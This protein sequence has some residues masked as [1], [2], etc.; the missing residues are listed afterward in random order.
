MFINVLDELTQGGTGQSWVD[1]MLAT[2]ACHSSVRAGQTLPIED[3]KSLLR[4]LEKTTH[5][6]TCPHGR[7]TLIQLSVNDLE[8]EF[9][10]R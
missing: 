3:A 4:Q 6:N 7:P 10:R 8:R 1:R 9:K 2:V 5:P